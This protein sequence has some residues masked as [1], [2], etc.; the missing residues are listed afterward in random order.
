MVA[1]KTDRDIFT[2]GTRSIDPIVGINTIRKLDELLKDNDR[3]RRGRGG[4]GELGASAV[5]KPDTPISGE[6]NRA[7]FSA[8]R[9]VHAGPSTDWIRRDPFKRI[10]QMIPV[11]L[12][13]K[14]LVKSMGSAAVGFRI[15]REEIASIADSDQGSVTLRFKAPGKATLT[16]PVESHSPVLVELM[17]RAAKR[18]R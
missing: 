10:T 3:R 13:R 16:I 8:A 1:F 18:S 11:G 12:T 5:V 9:L 14:L 6:V 2:R 4:D 7:G 15:D 17:V